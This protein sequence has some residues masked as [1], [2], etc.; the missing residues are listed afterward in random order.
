MSTESAESS[1]LGLHPTEGARALVVESDEPSRTWLRWILE[2]EGFVVYV[3]RDAA[4]AAG[5]DELASVVLI[6][7]GGSEPGIGGPDG[8]RNRFAS[9][10]WVLRVGREEE[11]NTLDPPPERLTFVF[12]KPF[13]AG[14]LAQAARELVRLRRVGRAPAAGEPR[15]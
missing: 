14:D 7:T 1:A 9:E 8:L 12:P 11:P 13:R 10:A 4:E 5:L 15:K 3:A 6:V 2:S